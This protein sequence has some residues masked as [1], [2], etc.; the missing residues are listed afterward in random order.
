MYDLSSLDLSAVS[1]S[2]EEI[3]RC[4]PQRHEFEQLDAIIAFRPEEEICIARK[5]VS[6]DEFWVRGHIPGEPLLPGVLMLEAAAQLSSFYLANSLGDGTSFYG[7][8]GVDKARF[9]STVRPGETLIILARPETMQPS[10][11]RFRTQGVVNGK[12]AFEA[13]IIGVRMS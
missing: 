1:H 4:N 12:L 6:E 3:L 7:F 10:R 2:H 5:D 8:G 9:R 11:S 13:T